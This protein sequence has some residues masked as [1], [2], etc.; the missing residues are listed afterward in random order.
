MKLTFINLALS[1]LHKI[2]AI[3]AKFCFALA[4]SLLIPLLSCSSVLEPNFHLMN[5]EELVAYNLER[6]TEE[7][8]NCVLIPAENNTQTTKLCGTLTEI[9]EHIEPLVPGARTNSF[10]FFPLGEDKSRSTNPTIKPTSDR[11]PL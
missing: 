1:K 2:P 10:S 8:I 6:T 11:R 3:N 7:Q 5:D 4:I 9:Q